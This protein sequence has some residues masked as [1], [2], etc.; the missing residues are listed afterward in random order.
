MIDL[1]SKNEHR[2]S[3]LPTALEN[4]RAEVVDIEALATVEAAA[5][6]LPAPASARQRVLFGR[7]QS[8]AT[9]TPQQA[10]AS[11]RFASR[12]RRLPRSSLG[13]DGGAPKDGRALTIE[14]PRLPIPKTKEKVCW[15]HPRGA[16]D[17]EQVVRV[18]VVS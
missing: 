14:T 2:L 8:L 18:S 10:S 3:R 15:G 17:C 12:T 7:I 11:L 1:Y 6:A 13:A 5:D 16:P 9:K 4:L